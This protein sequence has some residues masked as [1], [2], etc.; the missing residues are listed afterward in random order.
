[1]E[2]EVWVFITLTNLAYLF[3]A[4]L[5][6]ARRLYD[7]VA[8][9]AIVSIVSTAH[10][11]CDDAG[12]CND[13]MN[14][15]MDIVDVIVAYNAIATALMFVVNY[16]LVKVDERLN[17]DVSIYVMASVE[18]V[19][20]RYVLVKHTYADIATMIYYAVIVFAVLAFNGTLIEPIIIFSFGLL[21]VAMSFLFY[22]RMKINTLHKRFNGWFIL[23]AAVTAIA[24]TLLFTGEHFIGR[25]FHAV[26]HMG[27]AL[28][29]VFLIWGASNHLKIDALPCCSNIFGRNRGSLEKV[30]R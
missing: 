15:V 5:A 4:I 21:V 12:M 6:W 25:A 27:G 28:T 14:H 23:A 26:W 11:L 9:V 13:H 3:P 17:D 10:H 30:P 20:S 8:A 18:S 1:M 2:T 22:W 19:S 7:L 16:D 29:S 24:D